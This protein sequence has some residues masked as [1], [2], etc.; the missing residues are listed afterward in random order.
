[1]VEQSQRDVNDHAPS[2]L[3]DKLELGREPLTKT[4]APKP[5]RAW[6]RFGPHAVTVDAEA[7]AWTGRAVPISGR[8]RAGRSIAHE[9][10]PPPWSL[11]DARPNV[12]ADRPVVTPRL[13]GCQTITSITVTTSTCS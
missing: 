2:S 12:A 1:M 6:V 7:V 5:V 4:P 9:H 11:G 8:C 13:R 3:T 10:G